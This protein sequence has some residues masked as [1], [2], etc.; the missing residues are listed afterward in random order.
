MEIKKSDKANLERQR[1]IFFELGLIAA[2]GILLFAFEWTTSEVEDVD[3]GQQKFVE[4]EAEEAPITR[5]ENQPPPPPP[6]PPEPPKPEPSPEIEIVEDDVETDDVDLNSEA[7]EETTVDIVEFEEEEEVV[8]EEEIFFVVEDPPMFP[9]G[10]IE[11]AKF[12]QKNVVYPDEARENE[13]QGRVFVQFVVNK[14]GKVTQPKVVRS[15]HP[16]LDKAALEVVKSMPDW[17]PGKQ[18]GKSVSV[19]FTVPIN[20]ILN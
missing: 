4:I 13:I 11:L 3:L 8:E 6:P 20:F 1:T 9:G 7:D 10:Q 16:I 12:I 2:L 18:R 14:Q 17:T 19:S 15:V 5:Q